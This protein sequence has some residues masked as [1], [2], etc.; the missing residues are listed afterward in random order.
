MD[1]DGTWVRVSRYKS[2]DGAG[3][4]FV[5]TVEGGGHNWPGSAVEERGGKQR[6]FLGKGRTSPEEAR[7][8]TTHEIDAA[9]VIWQFFQPL[10]KS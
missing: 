10:H 8:K 3:D 1:G 7:G 9:T 4:V 6:R 2:A 5:Y